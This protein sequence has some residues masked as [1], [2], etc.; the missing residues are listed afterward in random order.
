MPKGVYNRQKA[1]PVAQP[2]TIKVTGLKSGDAILSPMRGG[3]KTAPQGPTIA[4]SVGKDG[5]E[6]DKFFPVRLLKGYRPFDKFKRIDQ[7]GNMFDPPDLK[8]DQDKGLYY[9]LMPNEV[10]GLPLPEAKELI[11]R[12]LAERADSLPE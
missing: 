3:P 2:E 12:G 1:E 7:D 8:P 4:E 5:L 10:Y 6:S 9:K 11:K